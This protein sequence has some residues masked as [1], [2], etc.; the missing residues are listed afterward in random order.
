MSHPPKA[1]YLQQ[2]RI[3]NTF[4]AIPEPFYKAGPSHSRN[5]RIPYPPA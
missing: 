1:R 3:E 4:R 5:S 2:K